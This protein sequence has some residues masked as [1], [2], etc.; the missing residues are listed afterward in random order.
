MLNCLL[1]PLYVRYGRA[2]T[3]HTCEDLN[4]ET[5]QQQKAKSTQSQ[6]ETSGTTI[7]HS[8]GRLSEYLMD[9]KLLLEK[10]YPQ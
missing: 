2:N 9:V 5:R 1:C 3:I 8:V 10:V 7:L 6:G 4:N